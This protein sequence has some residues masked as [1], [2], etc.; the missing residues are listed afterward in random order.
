MM[1][2]YRNVRWTFKLILCNVVS[3]ASEPQCMRASQKTLNYTPARSLSKEVSLMRRRAFKTAVLL[4][5]ITCSA[6]EAAAPGNVF[7]WRP[8]RAHSLHAAVI[9]AWGDHAISR[10]IQTQTMLIRHTATELQRRIATQNAKTYY[11]RLEPR[12]KDELKKKNIRYLAVPTVRSK[13]TS[14]KAKE[15]LM[16]WDIPRESLVGEYVYELETPPTIGE[17]ASYDKMRAE[18]IGKGP[19]TL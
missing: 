2:F 8:D 6:S 12:K 3:V 9:F 18:Y 19:E 16:V 11:A 17:V 4:T 1:D 14:P 10:S 5:S 7:D 15:V 13:Q